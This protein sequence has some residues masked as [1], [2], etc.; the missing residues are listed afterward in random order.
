[1]ESLA[2]L[3]VAATG[4]F[5]AEGVVL[6]RQVVRLVVA[7]G[8]GVIILGLVA[9]GLG[10]LLFGLFR[11][12]AVWLTPTGASVVLGVVALLLAWGAILYARRFLR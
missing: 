1:M 3:L 6:K 2:R 7:A 4:L 12:L 9:A 8:I 5:E 10:F 11:V